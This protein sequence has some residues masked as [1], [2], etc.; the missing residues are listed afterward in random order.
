MDNW[1]LGS[2]NKVHIYVN[3]NEIS[4]CGQ[5]EQKTSL[6]VDS[7]QNDNGKTVEK[8]LS[9]FNAWYYWQKHI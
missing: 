6:T 4:N 5:R 9:H 1:L 2:S 8:M 7:S 3:Y